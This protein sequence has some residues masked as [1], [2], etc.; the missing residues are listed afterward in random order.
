[1][2]FFLDLTDVQQQLLDINQ[3][4]EILGERLSDR[5]DELKRTMGDV[6]S[7]HQDIEDIL[8]WLKLKESFLHEDK[9]IPTNEK[10]AKAALAEF[11]VVYLFYHMQL[12]HIY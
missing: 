7:F 12:N 4:Y 8:T 11:E 2:L 1:M 5:Q 10:D 3:R 6:Q 9:A